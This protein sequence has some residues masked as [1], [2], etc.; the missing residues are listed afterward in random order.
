MKL[1]A[2]TALVRLPGRFEILGRACA[3]IP[4]DGLVLEFGVA[5]GATI[6]CIADALAPRPVYGFDWFHGLPEPWNGLPAGHFSCEPPDVPDNVELV[7]G[8]FADTLPLFLEEH[9]EDVAL[10]HL[11]CDIYSSTRTVLDALTP[12]IVSG[13]VLVFDEYWIA[14]DHERRAHIEWMAER[15]KSGTLDSSASEQACF[16]MD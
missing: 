7:I 13:T 5:S 1:V 16:V 12:R 8:L 6:R 3:L 10:L 11:D 14:P 4:R 9:R 2:A 15:G